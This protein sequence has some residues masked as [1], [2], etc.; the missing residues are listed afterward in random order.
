[1]LAQHELEHAVI[2]AG[3][4]VKAHDGKKVGAV[5]RLAFELPGGRLTRLIIRRG[6]LVTEEVE[7]PVAL[8]AGAGQGELALSIPAD[9]VATL[10]KLR[11]GLDVYASDEVCLGS[12]VTRYGEHVQVSGVDGRHPLYRA[13]G[14]G[15]A[16][17]GRPG[18]ARGGLWAGPRSGAR[19]RRRRPP[20]S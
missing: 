15:A 10:V 14:R 2:G 4:A 13:A 17:R 18:R 3:S 11:P 1:M 7:L 8:L 20:R 9:A 5:H 16:G 12:V 6:L 19:C